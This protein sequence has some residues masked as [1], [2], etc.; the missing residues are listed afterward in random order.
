MRT[1]ILISCLLITYGAFGQ[2]SGIIFQEDFEADSIQEMILKWDQAKNS[3]NMSFS[4]NFPEGSSGSQS[5]MMTYTPGQNT[6]GHLYKMFPEGY[7]SLFARFYVKFS[8]NH[9]KVHHFVHMGGYNPP[10]TWPQGGAGVKPEGNERFTTG[11]EPIGDKWSWDFYTY[12]KHMRGYADPN[13]FWGNTF[14]PDPPAPINRDEWICVELMMKINDPVDSYN[15]E[16][17]FWING[18]KIQ[19][20]GEGFPNGY[21]VWDKFYPNPDSLAFEGFQWRKDENLKLNFFW[22]LY[23]MTDGITGQTD[24]VLFDDVII[25]TEYTGPVVTGVTEPNLN[26]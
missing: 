7:D 16:M 24:T 20:L 10:T 21:W 19:H 6:G 11:I 22:L 25:S 23:Y 15:G 13:Y 9:S 1:F 26:K 12:W 14:H 3:A 18:E 8:A 5:L 4:S 17:A 2:E